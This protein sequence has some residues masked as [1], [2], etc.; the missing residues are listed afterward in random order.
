MKYKTDL[1]SLKK[2]SRI[3]RSLS[4]GPGGQRRDKKETAVSVHHL[5]SGLSVKFSNFRSQKRNEEEA[6]KKLKEKLEKINKVKK[7]RVSTKVPFKEKEKR[8]G[9]KKKISEKKKLRK[10]VF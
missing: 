8:I 7:K 3:L 1:K 4:S 6:F 2:E 9:E 10:P 5:P